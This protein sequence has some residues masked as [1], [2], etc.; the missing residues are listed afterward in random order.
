MGDLVTC[1]AVL[2]KNIDPTQV[3]YLHLTTKGPGDY[4]IIP[5]QPQGE[6]R[7]HSYPQGRGPW[8]YTEKDGRLYITPSLNCLDGKGQSYFHTDYNWS[9]A[10]EV[11]PRGTGGY[12]HWH[13]INPELAKAKEAEDTA[14]LERLDREP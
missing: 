11:C 8:N 1:K 9:T 10:Y 12:D 13:A 5:C 2:V 7:A 6:H 4:C 14:M 3:D